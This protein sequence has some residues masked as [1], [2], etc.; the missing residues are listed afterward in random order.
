[1]VRLLALCIACGMLWAASHAQADEGSTRFPQ[2]STKNLNDR[3]AT[4]PS[5]LPDKRAFV[6]VAFKRE[7]QAD[8]DV[9]IKKLALKK[10]NSPAWIEMPVVADYGSIWRAFVDNGMRSG[11]KH[12][13]PARAF[14]RFTVA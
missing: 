8:L 6:L 11:I 4:F 2:I 5:D 3:L 7:Q 14:L 13:E 9:W 1:M 10:A 12:K